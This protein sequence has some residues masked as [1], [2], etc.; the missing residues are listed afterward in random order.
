MTMRDLDGVCRIENI[1]FSAPWSRES[2]ETEVLK[3]KAAVSWIAERAGV[4]V[5]YLISWLVVDELHIGNIAVDPD[6]R[7]SGIGAALV[8]KSLGDAAAR[9]VTYATLEVRVSNEQAIALYERFSFRGVAMRTRYYSDTGE[10]A[11]VM[12][13][14]LSTEDAE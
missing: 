6:V 11:L 10:D 13:R 12:M 1:S 3:S 2:F 8:R 14:E 9:G 7:G 4:L 5:G